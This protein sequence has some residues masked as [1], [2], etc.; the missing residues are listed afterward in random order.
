MFIGHSEAGL[1]AKKYAKRVS[2]GTLFL[3]AQFIDLIW[4]S[5]L[6]LGWER[7][8]IE[9][10]ITPG[11]PLVFEHYAI[12]HSFLGVVLWALALGVTYFFLRK[13]IRGAIVL[14]MAVISHWVLDLVVHVPDLP[15]YPGDSPLLGLGLWNSVLWCWHSMYFSKSASPKLRIKEGVGASWA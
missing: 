10:G 15:L 11:V 12:S 7:A 1:I 4:P 8:R 3:A 13:Q 9:P 2:L 5:L 14:G 6:L